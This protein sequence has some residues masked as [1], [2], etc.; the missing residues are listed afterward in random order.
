MIICHFSDHL[1]HQISLELCSPREAIQSAVAY[2]FIFLCDSQLMGTMSLR[3]K[4]QLQQGVLKM[5]A[6]VQTQAVQV[7]GLGK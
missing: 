1:L 4:Q 6:T 2:L 5:L 7:N 3:L